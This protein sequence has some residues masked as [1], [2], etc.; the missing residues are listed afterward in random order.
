MWHP[1]KYA[2]LL[3]SKLK[4]HQANVWLVNTGWSGGS[5]GTGSRMS[6]KITRAII[7]AIHSGALTNVKTQA[8]PFF[9]FEIPTACPGVP[10]EMLSPRGTWKDAAAYD[11]TARRLS[12]L[13]R[14]NF[15]KYETNVGPEVWFAGPK[16]DG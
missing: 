3:A 10:A 16:T 7:N 15:K 1:A 9:G 8:D 11:V 2:E 5:Y 13:F 14:E 12:G 6:L 4:Q